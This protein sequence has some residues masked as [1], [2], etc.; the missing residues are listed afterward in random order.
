MANLHDEFPLRIGTRQSENQHHA[1]QN[2]AN[3][4][5]FAIVFLLI[6]APPCFLL[7]LTNCTPNDF[8]SPLT[9]KLIHRR[10]AFGAAVRTR[11]MFYYRTG[12]LS[13]ATDRAQNKLRLRLASRSRRFL[14]PYPVMRIQRVVWDRWDHCQH[15]VCLQCLAISF[16]SDDTHPLIRIPSQI[17][18]DNKKAPL[19]ASHQRSLSDKLR[20]AGPQLIRF[21]HRRL[22][23]VPVR[24]KFR[25]SH[26]LD[27]TADDD[28]PLANRQYIDGSAF[29]QLPDLRGRM[30]NFACLW[31]RRRR[32]TLLSLDA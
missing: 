19:A 26:T 27:Q 15:R 18:P 4:T 31:K 6:L 3:Q 5:A 21:L 7:A 30:K 25:P 20:N 24:Q 29:Q 28:H 9:K 12:D 14:E 22:P 17:A 2:A 32:K 13:P 8:P 1:N 11:G 23:G 10:P 16:P